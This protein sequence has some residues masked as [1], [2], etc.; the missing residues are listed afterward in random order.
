MKF[1][2]SVTKEMQKVS[3]AFSAAGAVESQ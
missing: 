1:L 2:S 3:R